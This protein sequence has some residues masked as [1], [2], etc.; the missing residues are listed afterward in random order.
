MRIEVRHYMDAS[1]KDLFQ[2]WVDSLRDTRGKIAILRRVDRL[3]LGNA[4]DHAPCRDGVWELRID[5][6]PGYRIYIGNDGEAIVVLLGGGNKD[7]QQ[8][9]IARAIAAWNDYKRRRSR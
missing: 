4:G 5:Q 2:A 6:G 3:E 1:G 9:D 7:T 8:R